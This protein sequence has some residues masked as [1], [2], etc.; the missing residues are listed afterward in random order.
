MK[1]IIKVKTSFYITNNKLNYVAL[2]KKVIKYLSYTGDSL[3]QHKAEK[4]LK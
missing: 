3:K 2:S 4:N 1:S